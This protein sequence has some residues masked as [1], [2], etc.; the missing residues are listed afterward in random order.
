VLAVDTVA[1]GVGVGAGPVVAVSAP[2]RADAVGR[3]VSMA[4]PAVK[5][6]VDFA[7]LMRVGRAVRWVSA[8]V[9]EMYSLGRAGRAVRRIVQGWRLR[10]R[11][12]HSLRL[13]QSMAGLVGMPR[14]A[15]GGI[16]G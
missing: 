7:G 13:V 6:R 2:V 4:L 5:G 11:N 3:R 1:A 8:V 12:F 15:A 10:S 9:V 14:R 16:V